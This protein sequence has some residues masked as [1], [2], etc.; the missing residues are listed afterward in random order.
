MSTQGGSPGHQTQ[1]GELESGPP[2]RLPVKNVDSPESK[3][4]GRSW[5]I[6]IYGKSFAREPQQLQSMRLLSLLSRV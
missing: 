2:P 1:I 5:A 6:T 3:A 4:S